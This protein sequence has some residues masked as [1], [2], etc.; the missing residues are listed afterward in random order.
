MDR[1]AEKYKNFDQKLYPNIQPS[2]PDLRII[3]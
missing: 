2:A 1:E 3:D